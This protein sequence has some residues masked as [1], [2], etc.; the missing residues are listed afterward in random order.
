M[1]L[2]EAVDE[3]EFFLN[4]PWSDGLP[5]VTPTEERVQWMLQGAF[6]RR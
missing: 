2:T 5:M 6:R 4:K 3:F 1:E